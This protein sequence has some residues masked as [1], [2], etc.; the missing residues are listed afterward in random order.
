MRLCY[1]GNFASIHMRR[2]ATFF[3]KKGHDV[4]VI[5]STA[6]EDSNSLGCE[7]HSLPAPRTGSYLLDLC[8]TG[9]SMPV[10]VIQFR[11]LFQ[12]IA[13]DV[14]HVHYLNDM[15]LIS[16]LSGVRPIVL[17]A[18][19][20]DIVDSPEKSWI[21]KKAVKYMVRRADLMTC[22]AD[23]MKRRIV[24]FGANPEK[25]QVIF[26]GTDVRQFQPGRRALELRKQLAPD[27]SLLVISIRNLE[28][29]YDVETLIRAIPI[30]RARFPN[31]MVLI[32]GSGSQAGFLCHLAE[33]LGIMNN[34][35][36]VGPL[37]Q[38]ELPVYLASSDVY[39]STALSDGGIAASTAE[40][41]AS[42][43]P[44]VITDVGNNSQWV[45][46]DLHGFLVP[47]RS[48]EIL[49]EKLM[50]LLRDQRLRARM[51]IAGRE[52]IVERNNLR[53]QMSRMEELYLALAKGA[54]PCKTE[55]G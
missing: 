53:Q 29:I 49:A 36:F 19:G 41:M 39:V 27:G 42:R 6:W 30:V 18:W 31:A 20:S 4:H 51:G 9:V 54:R 13:A 28:P 11:R 33:K 45:E 8:V 52:V 12:K 15:A 14:A 16:L 17:T 44:V 38:E 21:R 23:H 37:S 5:S 40:A 35:R 50:S 3:A 43:L 34:V 24:Q 22:D 55:G 25:V 10:R 32:A 26:F 48:P 1:V 7:V 46:D 47:P 2:W